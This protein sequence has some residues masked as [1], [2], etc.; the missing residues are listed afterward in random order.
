MTPAP[1]DALSAAFFLL[2]MIAV[3]AYL[4]GHHL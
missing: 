1:S 3:L 4:Q 2:V